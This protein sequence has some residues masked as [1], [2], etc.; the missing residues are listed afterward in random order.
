MTFLVKCTPTHW[1]LNQDALPRDPSRVIPI[2]R[3]PARVSTAGLGPCSLIAQFNVPAATRTAQ[4]P[5]LTALAWEGPV[6]RQY[7]LWKFGDVLAEFDAASPSSGEVMLGPAGVGVSG[8]AVFSVELQLPDEGVHEVGTP[9]LRMEVDD[10]GTPM[11]TL[12]APLEAAAHRRR[13]PPRDVRAIPGGAR[14]LPDPLGGWGI[15]SFDVACCEFVDVAGVYVLKDMAASN[16][17]SGSVGIDSHG[18]PAIVSIEAASGSD[19]DVLLRTL[20]GTP[21]EPSV[22][23]FVRS[24]ASAPTDVQV[25]V[26]PVSSDPIRPVADV[27]HI[28]VASR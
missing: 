6:P 28:L 3:S 15:T 11:M 2:A 8:R 1:W 25:Q 26:S 21:P 27:K 20:V 10:V 4:L 22:V 16:P 19:R 14:C 7:R 13:R 23:R 9:H 17:R 5:M 18:R 12:W 24:D